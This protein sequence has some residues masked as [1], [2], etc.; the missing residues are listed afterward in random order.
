M[1]NKEALLDEQII[2]IKKDADDL[3]RYIR[4]FPRPIEK[5]LPAMQDY[6]RRLRNLLNDIV[7]SHNMHS[8]THEKPWQPFGAKR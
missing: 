3:I 7:D 6:R 8:D 5:I 1:S 4:L 2:L